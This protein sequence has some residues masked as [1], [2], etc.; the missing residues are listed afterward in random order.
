MQPVTGFQVA[1]VHSIAD[2]SA[3]VLNLVTISLNVV[4]HTVLWWTR[5]CKVKEVE[6]FKEL[7][8]YA[9]IE[10]AAKAALA[11]E[12]SLEPLV[13]VEQIHEMPNAPLR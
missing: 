11:F 4:T 8:R 7:G 9:R 10:P 6:L 1:S 2:I 3:T 5:P 13:G 12:T